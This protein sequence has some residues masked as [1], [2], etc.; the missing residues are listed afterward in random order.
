MHIITKYSRKIPKTNIKFY[1]KMQKPTIILVRTQMPE[2][3]GAAARAM[4]N[5]GLSALRLV[6]PREQFPDQRAYDLAGHASEILDNTK[7]FANVA[8]AVADMQVLYATTAR[9]RDLQK[10]EYTPLKAAQAI[11][12]QGL[13]TAILFGPERTGLENEDLKLVDAIITIPTAGGLASLNIAQ[14]VVV[15]AYQLFDLSLKADATLD[16]SASEPANKSELQGLFDHLERKLDEVNFWKVP[17]KKAKMWQNLQSIFA[18]SKLSEQEVRS[19]HG[20]IATIN[21]PN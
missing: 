21:L 10:S 6:S 9:R 14:S 15:I 3:I 2:N 8:D 7:V 5:F 19:L 1:L 20:V 16:S 13:K 17:T 12:E 18:R 4:M 11:A